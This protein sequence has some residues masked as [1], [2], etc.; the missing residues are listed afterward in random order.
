M[1]L[2]NKHRESSKASK[3]AQ[4]DLENFRI[5]ETAG[6]GENTVKVTASGLHQLIKVEI[7]NAAYQAGREIIN[8]LFADAYNRAIDKIK[9]AAENKMA[10]L[11]GQMSLPKELTQGLAGG[12]DL[13]AGVSPNAQM[14]APDMSGPFGEILKQAQKMQ[15]ELKQTQQ[16]LA[17]FSVIGK[18]GVEPLLAKVKMTGEHKLSKVGISPAAYK[19]GKGMVEE[20]LAGAVNDAVVGVKKESERKMMSLLETMRLPQDF[21]FDDEDEDLFKD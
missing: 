2:L 13:V 9:K 14:P 16:E 10:D 20:L 5:E 21:N 4:S 11:M 17:G 15:Q 12:N 6:D 19:E 18:S 8:G 1:K 3:K 7:S